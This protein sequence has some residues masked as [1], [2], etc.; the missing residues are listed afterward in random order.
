MSSSKTGTPQSSY[1]TVE[2]VNINSVGDLKHVE[3]M[4]ELLKSK[5]YTSFNPDCVRKK[6]N[7]TVSSNKYKFDDES[8][9]KDLFLNDIAR[10]SPKLNALLK[11]I[12][13]LDKDDEDKYGRKFKH[14][15]FSELKSGTYGAKMIASAMIAS[16]FSM[17][18]YAPQRG[19]TEE[20]TPSPPTTNSIPILSNIQESISA[21]TSPSSSPSPSELSSPSSSDESLLS[22]NNSFGSP[23]SL[24]LSFS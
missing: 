4:D 1:S 8:F 18:Y 24:G 20:V 23:L 3:N 7:W 22:F 9:D 6:S 10:N 14:F 15:I 19:Q 2:S 12:E 5:Y 13:K 17:A 16:G 11:N 21:L